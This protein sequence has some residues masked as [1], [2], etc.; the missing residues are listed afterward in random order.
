MVGNTYYFL[1]GGRKDTWTLK[2]FDPVT[3]TLLGE[4]LMQRDPQKELGNDQ[5][6]AYV[7]GM[8]DASGLHDMAGIDQQEREQIDPSK[9]RRDPTKRRGY[10]PPVLY[11]RPGI[12][13]ILN[14]IRYTS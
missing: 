7:N 14:L 1:T 8:L 13:G 11:H 4:T 10:T 5:M 12:S 9:P 6:L 2:K 3:W